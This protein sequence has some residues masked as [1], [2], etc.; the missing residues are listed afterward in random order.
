MFRHL[1]LGTLLLARMGG[2]NPCTGLVGCQPRCV[3]SSVPNTWVALMTMMMM[4][5]QCLGWLFLHVLAAD[6]LA[7]IVQN[8]ME[9]ACMGHVRHACSKLSNITVSQSTM[10]K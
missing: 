8:G 10:D 7:R 5:A 4:L 6:A 9:R 3:T 2:S 1:F